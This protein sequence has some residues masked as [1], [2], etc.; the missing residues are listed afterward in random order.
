[1]TS[2]GTHCQQEWFGDDAVPEFKKRAASLRNNDI[3]SLQKRDPVCVTEIDVE[4]G[5]LTSRQ[6]N[7]Y[8]P[9][10]DTDW[11]LQMTKIDQRTPAQVWATVYSWVVRCTI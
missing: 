1:V 6:I 8:Y 9:S 4:G 7:S 5:V 2:T 11:L 3:R 10:T